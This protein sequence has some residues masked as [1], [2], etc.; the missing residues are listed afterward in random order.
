MLLYLIQLR[1]PVIFHTSV[2]FAVVITYL[3]SNCAK[4]AG[5][6][7]SLFAFKTLPEH[8]FIK[9][10]MSIPKSLVISPSKHCLGCF[11]LK[12][13]SYLI[14]QTIKQDVWSMLGSFF[15]KDL[16][17]IEKDWEGK[18]NNGKIRR[19]FRKAKHEFIKILILP[20]ICSHWSL[21]G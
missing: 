1:K 11:Q 17:Q 10:V 14:N 5:S 12:D 7:L 19:A 2:F 9:C 15:T 8:F 3:S 21:R 18:M 20:I 4:S 6:E 16:V 13:L